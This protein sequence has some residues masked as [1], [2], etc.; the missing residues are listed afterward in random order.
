MVGAAL[1]IVAEFT[2]LFTVHSTAVAAA[3]KTV[4]T[5]SHHGYA[6]IPVAVLAAVLSGIA[7]RTGSRPALLGIGAMGVV[8]LVIALL[9]D[10]PDAQAKGLVTI[11]GH[12]AR[13]SATP[14]VGFYLESLGG[15]VL[16]IVA[17]GG[18]LLDPSPV[19]RRPR[20]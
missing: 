12:L 8:A 10:L 20:A 5:G 6:L 16:L 19:A 11:G 4:Q 3:I 14:S 9:G 13:A 17:A 7:R 2:T 15:V 18:L 1:L